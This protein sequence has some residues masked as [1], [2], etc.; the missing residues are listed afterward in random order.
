LT[1]FYQLMGEKRRSAIEAHALERLQE[2]ARVV[3]RRR[4]EGSASGYDQSR[5]EIEAELAAS[6]LRQTR[7]GVERLRVELARLLG[8]APNEAS[9]AGTL[10]ADASI[11]VESASES[12]GDSPSSLRLLRTAADR[13]AQA[14]EAASWSWLPGLVLSGGPRLGSGDKSGDGYEL[15]IAMDLP[16][17]SRGQELR[18]RAAAGERYAQAHAEAAER[19]VQIERV[20]SAQVLM[21]ARQEAQ[22]FAETTGERI[23]RLERAAQSGY[24]EGELSIVELLDAQRVRTDLELRQLELA[25]ALK[26]AEVALCAA[27]GDYE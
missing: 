23:D 10:E 18:S 14:S 4:E 1:V 25:L 3:R 27:R 16:I 20:R 5:I 9:F 24:R 17:F 2:A 11:V 26:E 19:A 15:G 21:A 7:A 12:K 22:R 13:A 8:V 6:T